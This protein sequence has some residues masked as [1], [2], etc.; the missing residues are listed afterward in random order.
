LQI[1]FHPYI[2][3]STRLIQCSDKNEDELAVAANMAILAKDYRNTRFL[4]DNISMHLAAG[5]L[6]VHWMAVD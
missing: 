3:S 1:H 5:E 2:L 4:L 6:D